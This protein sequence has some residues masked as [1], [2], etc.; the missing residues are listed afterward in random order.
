MEERDRS[1]AWASLGQKSTD[2]RSAFI[3]HV[4]LTLQP[5]AQ[6][7]ARRKVLLQN[8]TRGLQA[9]FVGSSRTNKPV[10]TPTIK[11]GNQNRACTKHRHQ[12]DGERSRSIVDLRDAL[13]C[14]CADFDLASRCQMFWRASALALQGH[15]MEVQ[16]SLAMR[17]EVRHRRFEASTHWQVQHAIQSLDCKPPR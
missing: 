8:P 3:M 10:A 16:K 6:Q 1:S 4:E 2:S 12:N 5:E 15:S 14:G 17:T 11:S 13:E 9:A 7:F